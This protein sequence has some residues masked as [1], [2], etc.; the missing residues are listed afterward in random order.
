MGQLP[1]RPFVRT[2][3][4]LAF[5]LLWLSSA[6][7]SVPLF[8][9]A[10]PTPT[11]PAPSEEPLSWNEVEQRVRPATVLVQFALPSGTTYTVTGVAYAQGLVLTIVPPLDEGPPEQVTIRL[12]DERTSRP[13]RLLG[14]SPCDGVAVL[15]IDATLAQLAPLGTPRAPDI[16]EDV[17][18]YGYAAANPDGPA[19]SVPA[20]LAGT[21]PDRLRG[22]DQLGVNVDLSGLT[23]GSLLID[24]YGAVLGLFLPSGLFVPAGQAREVAET[25][26]EGRGLLWLG[27]GLSPHRNPEHYGTERGLVVLE[28]SPGGPAAEAGI[29]PGMLLARIDGA[30]IERFA[31]ACQVLRQHRQGD[32]L[33]LELRQPLTADIRVLE[34]RIRIGEPAPATPTELRREL[35]PR[36]ARPAQQYV[37]TF[38]RAEEASDWPTGSSQLGTGEIHDGHYTITLTQ[39]NAFGIFEPVSLPLGTDQRI[40]AT[41]SLPDEAG[42][43]LVV[44]SSQDT[45]GARNFY[46]CAVIRTSGQ[47]V[48][49]CSIAL[50]GEP[51]V[52]H[53]VRPLAGVDP[54][55]D[56]LTLEL[57]ARGTQLVFRVAGQTVAQLDDPLLGHGRAGL[58][59]ESFDTVPV[60]VRFDEVQI[61]LVP[62]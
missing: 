37:W 57:E 16:G 47:L 44:R 31:Q 13:A 10:T 15:G 8:S 21:L 55:S 1:R 9:R 35:S 23:A 4:L 36:P 27:L 49:T 43:G 6:C 56:P 39:P 3:L 58:W 22:I 38:D 34:T 30:E 61:D 17:L 40:A 53:P 11:A 54:A 24:R 33:R 5:A 52:L 41:V 28:V 46:L 2:A 51:A 42:V 48:A 19:V 62:R 7:R 60:T 14:A 29:E 32:E 45:D 20:A 50:A 59:V 25:L 26:A 18:V 12:P